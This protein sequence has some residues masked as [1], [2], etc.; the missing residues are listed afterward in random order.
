MNEN[1]S[2]STIGLLASGG[3]DSS[4]LLGHLLGGGRRVQPFFVRAGLRWEDA[5][6]RQLGKFLRVLASPRLAELVVLDLPLADLYGD[7][8]SVTGRG[9]P[10][11]ASPDAAVYL[12]GRN[13]LLLVKLVLSVPA[14]R[15]RG[16]GLGRVGDQPVRRCAAGVFR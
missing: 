5:E 11:F 9:V 12:P 6:R 7:H 15:H 16:A 8:W 4:I 2:P 14:A 13:A 1:A 3:L 10:E